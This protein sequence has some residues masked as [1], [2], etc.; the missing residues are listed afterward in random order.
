M[1]IIRIVKIK[2][3]LQTT[4]RSRCESVQH[5][6]YSTRYYFFSCKV[7]IPLDLTFV[8]DDAFNCLL[9]LA[10]RFANKTGDLLALNSK[11]A[12]KV[13]NWLPK[14]HMVAFFTV[15]DSVWNLQ[16]PFLG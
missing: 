7:G 6:A 14:N 12:S 8:F 2:R 3:G 13:Y 4:I 1:Q 10:F 11:I 16:R 15:L 5:Q 9:T